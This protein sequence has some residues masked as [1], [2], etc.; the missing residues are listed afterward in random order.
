MRSLIYPIVI[1][2][3]SSCQISG[4]TS[5]YSHLSD[6]SKAKVKK[7]DGKIADIADYSFV[8]AVTP[9]QVKEYLSAREDVIVYNYTPYCQSNECISPEALVAKCR[10]KGYDVLVISNIY[11]DLMSALNTAFPIFMINTDV[12]K[13]KWRGKY[14]DE[15]YLPLIGKVGKQVDYASYH[16]FHGGA[17]VRSYEDPAE[18]GTP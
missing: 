5:G 10:E 6:E 12:M 1:L 9:A 8:Y 15:F 14:I 2:L 17:Y 11:D 7:Y 16:Y 3:L 18:I 4:L 13:T